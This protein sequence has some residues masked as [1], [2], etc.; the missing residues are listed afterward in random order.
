MGEG[1]RRTL[2]IAI[3]L[4]CVLLL[5]A[6][7]TR[8]SDDQMIRDFRLHQ[9]AYV[10]LLGMFQADAAVER[11]G[12][13]AG[14]MPADLVQAG[15]A[16]SRVDRYRT[17]M[18]SV[19]AVSIERSDAGVLFITSS[20]GLAGTGTMNG[21]L[22]SARPPSPLVGDTVATRDA[23]DALDGDV[24]RRIGDGWYLVYDWTS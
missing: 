22:Y 14:D 23:T 3:A 1:L 7:G 17:L 9:A 2:L 4:S 13:L 24:Y 10:E 20:E 19:G 21:Y 18:R 8:A 5:T 15:L 12:T 6:C 11:I 16:T